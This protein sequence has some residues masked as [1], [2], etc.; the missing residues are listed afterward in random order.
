MTMTMQPMTMTMQP[1]TMQ[2]M[3]FPGSDCIPMMFP[4]G[5]ETQLGVQNVN[6]V[7]MPH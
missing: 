7:G 5:D 3:T 4:T 6:Q 1:M 2:P